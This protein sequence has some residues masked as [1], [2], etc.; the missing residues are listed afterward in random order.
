MKINIIAQ[1]FEVSNELERYIH[2]KVTKLQRYMPRSTRKM[3]HAEA[4]LTEHPANST[5]RY[6]CEI[7]IRLSHGEFVAKESTINM[8]AAID[9]VEAKLRNQLLRFK[10]KHSQHIPHHVRLWRQIRGGNR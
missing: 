7:I 9:I 4:H 5:N 2:Q 8:F 3:A 1:H 6:T 10:Q